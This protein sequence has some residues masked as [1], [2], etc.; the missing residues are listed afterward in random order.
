VIENRVVHGNVRMPVGEERLR[1]IHYF[2]VFNAIACVP[3]TA[4]LTYIDVTES[5]LLESDTQ[6]V[7]K[8]K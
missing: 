5:S 7:V 3:I 1:L 6:F 4:S 2:N 8:G